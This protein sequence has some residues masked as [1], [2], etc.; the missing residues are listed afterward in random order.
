MKEALGPVHSA[1]L[2]AQ[3]W[4]RELGITKFLSYFQFFMLEHPKLNNFLPFH[5]GPNN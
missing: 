4:T 3:Q 5:Q 2:A 1:E